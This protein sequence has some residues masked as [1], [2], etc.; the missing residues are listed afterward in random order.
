MFDINLSLVKDTYKVNPFC[1]SD[2]RDWLKV[3]TYTPT[4]QEKQSASFDYDNTWSKETIH[5]SLFQQ[6]AYQL[7]IV[8]DRYISAPPNVKYLDIHLTGKLLLA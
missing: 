6:N 5:G 1:S 3:I 2:C 4:G 7:K 8:Y